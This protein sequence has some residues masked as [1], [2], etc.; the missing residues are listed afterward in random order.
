M[1]HPRRWGV[2]V[3]LFH[4]PKC[5]TS[6]SVTFFGGDIKVLTQILAIARQVLYHLN[7]TTHPVLLSLFFKSGLTLYLGQP[8]S[9]ASYLC[10]LCS[11][12]CRDDGHNH[13]TWLMDWDGVLWN[14]CLAWPW[15]VILLISASWIAEISGVCHCD[16]VTVGGWGHHTGGLLQQKPARQASWVGLK[17]EG[18]PKMCIVMSDCWM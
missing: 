13:R 8:G 3:P 9:W 10:F 2:A 12:L 7:Y 17:V 14:F 16:W 4:I 6:V 1:S 11:L 15:T 18:L 5:L